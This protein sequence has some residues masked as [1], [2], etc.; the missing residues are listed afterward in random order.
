MEERRD[1]RAWA[2]GVVEF[3]QVA[4]VEEV[5][6]HPEAEAR[7]RR[8]RASEVAEEECLLEAAAVALRHLLRVALAGRPASARRI[9]AMAVAFQASVRRQAEEEEPRASARRLQAGAEDQA[10]ALQQR[11]PVPFAKRF[12]LGAAVVA[13]NLPRGCL[14]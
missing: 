4:E 6:H 9:Q 2:A 3:L 1:L 8:R 13:H 7:R 14:A 5:V 11:E 10:W 12:P